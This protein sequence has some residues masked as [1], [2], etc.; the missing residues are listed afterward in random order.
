MAQDT[1]KKAEAQPIVA[2]KFIAQF[3]VMP[4]SYRH[5]KDVAMV[6]PKQPEKKQIVQ[7]PPVPAKPLPPKPVPAAPIAKTSKT[8]KA[9]LIAGIIV[10]VALGIGGYLVL[11]SLQKQP[12]AGGEP[13]KPSS[14][15]V[16]PVITPPPRSAP[17]EPEVPVVI[18]PTPAPDLTLPRQFIP[19][20]DTDADGLSDI[21][22]QLIYETS[23]NLPDS[24]TDGFLDGNEVFH[25]YN[26]N[27]SSSGTLIGSGLAL[28]R[29]DG[30][31]RMT[32]PKIWTVGE[33]TNDDDPTFSS[34]LLFV[35][36]TGE[37]IRVSFS[38][39][40]LDP[41]ALLAVWKASFKEAP[42]GSISKARHTLFVSTDNSQAFLVVG[43]RA[44]RFTY[45]QGL[46][47]TVDYLQTFQMMIN[48]VDVVIVATPTVVPAT[49]PIEVVEPVEPL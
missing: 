10:L 20:R 36:T 40:G 34:G 8:T 15:G 25:Q 48:S 14:A 5:G 31:I 49:A 29:V 3:F 43:D 6:E 12:A 24:D 30:N 26:P 44:V 16:E 28:E 19:G 1:D 4:E 9:I 23:P 45:D 38:T 21:E 7:V 13:A 39:L 42:I 33:R 27:E 17:V 41:N 2:S 18:E 47:S 32:Y 22:E 35:T 11:R 37:Q 46:K